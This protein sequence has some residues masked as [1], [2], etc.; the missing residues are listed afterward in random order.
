MFQM[1]HLLQTYVALKCFMLQVLPCF[2]CMFKE[3]WGH[4]PAD[5]AGDAPWVLRTGRAR[6][7]PGSRVL[8]AQR[9]E[10]SGGT[11]EGAVGAGQGD[12]DGDGVHV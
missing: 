11:G 10:R 2:R 3:S 5:G 12:A 9:E 4:G 8:P 7:H 1:F 6:S